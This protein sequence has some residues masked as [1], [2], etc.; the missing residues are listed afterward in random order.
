M[1][2]KRVSPGVDY[3]GI[4]P[5]QAIPAC[6]KA[7][8]VDPTNPRLLFNL[9]RAHAAAIVQG[10]QRAGEEELAGQNIKAA[11]DRDYPAA[12]MVLANYYWRGIGG[13]GQDTGEAI[14][15]LERAALSDAT[16]AKR[17]RRFLFRA[18]IVI[19]P[20][21]AQM[22]AVKEAADGGDAEALY[23]LGKQAS[24]G[25]ESSKA[26]AAALW[27]KAAA[28]GSAQA[29]ADLAKMYSKGEGGLSKNLD[30]GKRLIEQAAT[31]DDPGARSQAAIEYEYG[32]IV[33][34]DENKAVHLF[35]QASNE[36]DP[37]ASYAI[38]KLYDEGG[39]G[40]PQNAG[41]AAPFY[42]LAADRGVEDAILAVAR[43]MKEGLGGYEPDRAKAVEFLKRA[44]RWSKKAKE[45][46]AAMGQSDSP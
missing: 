30:E 36:G 11:A 1:D 7:L 15:L 35:E 24:S 27:R 32:G 17:Q 34:E 40:L 41:K 25:D 42:K 10:D 2:P 20:N 23:V 19:R 9:G 37:Y 44:A 5:N 12:Q 28:L 4:N 21:D 45:Q 43:Y 46:L 33:S 14:R 8:A 26:A 6:E 31:G 29:A 13:F 18:A 3:Y 22:R 38:G 39:A 16:L